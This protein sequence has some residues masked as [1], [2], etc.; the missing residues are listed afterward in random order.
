MKYSL[1]TFVYYKY[2]LEE[3]IKRIA[4]FGYHGVEIWAGRPHA[5]YEDMTDNRINEIRTVLE[6][7]GLQISNFI[8]AQFRYP[9]NIAAYDETIRRNSVEYIKGNID[10]A[11]KF[12]APFVSLCPGFSMYGK[13]S[14]EGWN[15]MIK[16]LGELLDYSTGMPVKLLL[17]PGNRAETDLVVTVDDGLRAI[18]QLNYRM[19]IL[20]D[21]GHL[22]VNKESVSDVIE[23]VKGL[24]CHYHIDDNMGVSDDHLVPG[25]GKMYYDTFI[26]KL[27]ESGYNGY[28]A[29]E[30][31]FGYCNDPD[32]AVKKSIDY[33]KTKEDKYERR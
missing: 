1:S 31:G 15:C 21:T 16:S 10:V 22:F 24:T 5:Y 29:V 7:Y 32:I 19:G 17:E 14:E 9:T 4:A 18:D 26:S 3:A 13:S 30:L 28:L 6:S 8:P 33:L 20:P 11:V 2:P 25:E 23:K 27:Y 12:E